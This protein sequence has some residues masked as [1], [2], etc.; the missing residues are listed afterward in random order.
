VDGEEVVV[1]EGASEGG[2][3]VW[4]TRTGFFEVCNLMMF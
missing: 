4:V 1:K 3:L 2:A